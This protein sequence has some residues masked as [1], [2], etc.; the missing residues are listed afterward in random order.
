MGW[1]FT[2]VLLALN[3]IVEERIKR[4]SSIM[5]IVQTSLFERYQSLFHF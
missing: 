4:H 1:Q 3:P 5:S 2:K